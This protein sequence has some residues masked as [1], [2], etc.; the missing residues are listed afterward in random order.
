MN[1]AEAIV[2]FPSGIL[3]VISVSKSESIFPLWVE[4]PTFSNALGTVTFNGGIPNP[5]YSGSAGTLVTVTFRAKQ[6]GTASVSL[7]G[8]AVRANDG[9]GT[10]ILSG[11]SGAQIDIRAVTQTPVVPPTTPTTPATPVETPPVSSSG[12]LALR[13]PTHPSPDNWYPVVKPI[14]QWTLPSGVTQVQTVLDRDPKAGPRVTYRPAISEK[15]LEEL[16]EGVWYFQIRYRDAEGWSD[17]S[18]YRIQIDSI[19]PNITS[20]EF[21]YDE[22]AGIAYVQAPATDGGSG[23]DVYEIVIDGASPIRVAANEF[24]AAPYAIPITT[25]GVHRI[26][27]TA[28]D[29]ANNSDVREG[30]ISVPVP[31]QERAVWRIGKNDITVRE[32]IL[33]AF[34]VGILSVSLAFLALLLIVVHHHRKHKDG[35]R[36]RSRHV[37]TQKEFTIL[38]RNIERDMKALEKLHA[39]RTLDRDEL[40]LYHRTKQTLH[41]LDQYIQSDAAQRSESAEKNGSNK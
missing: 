26:S 18:S 16:D 10:D 34:L 27:V 35:G 41:D 17:M 39:D 1:N 11:T 33:W 22:S 23:V 24:M 32:A 19:A 31:L 2:N 13:S 29:K 15:V 21:V 28:Y 40:E 5:G 6:A 14:V 20:S 37:D 4:E 8:A 36:D 30:T 38:K 3:E 25:S 7:A 9:L 12:P